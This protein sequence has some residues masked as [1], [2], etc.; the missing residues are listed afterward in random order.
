MNLQEIGNF[1]DDIDNY[2][3]SF[4]DYD[5]KAWSLN[6]NTK[7]FFNWLIKFRCSIM[8]DS[9]NSLSKN[10]DHDYNCGR[11]NAIGEIIE[12]INIHLNDKEEKQN[13]GE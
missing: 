8:I 11:F 12:K 4:S 10:N 3:D 13:D 1:L 6:P 7:C 5:W 2:E 9:I